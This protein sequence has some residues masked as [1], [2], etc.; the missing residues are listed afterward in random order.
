MKGRSLMGAGEAARHLGVS[1]RRARMIIREL[2]GE[3]ESMGIATGRG[4]VDRDY[5]IARTEI[6]DESCAEPDAAMETNAAEEELMSRM[7]LAAC[8][9]EGQGGTSAE[10]AAARRML[11]SVSFPEAGRSGGRRQ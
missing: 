7:L 2:N 11:L 5:F 1:G 10:E 9:P 4:R 8:M 6:I 3:L